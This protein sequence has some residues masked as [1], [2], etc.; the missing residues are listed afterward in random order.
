MKTSEFQR[1]TLLVTR[2]NPQGIKIMREMTKDGIAR[3]NDS[4]VLALRK[5]IKKH[6]R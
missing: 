1:L 6:T 3:K 4:V 2:I 5:Q